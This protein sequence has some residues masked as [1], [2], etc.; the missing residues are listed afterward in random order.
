MRLFGI[1]AISGAQV[2]VAFG[3]LI[4]GVDELVEPVEDLPYVAPGWIDLQVNGYA[5]VDYNSPETAHEEIA[6]SIAAQ[7]Q[8]GT[9]RILATVITG[10]PENML[11]SLRNLAAAKVHGSGC[12]SIEG[13][14]VEGP[15]IS[16]E[17]GPRGAHPSRWVRPPAVDEYRRWQEVSDGWVKMVT[18]AP[19]WPGATAYIEELVRDGVVVAIGHTNATAVEIEEAVRAGATLSTHLGNGAHAMLPRQPNYIWDQLAD[20]RLAASFI[21][22]GHHLGASFLKTALRAKGVLRSVLVTDATMPAGSIPGPYEFGELEVELT[23]DERVVLRGSA[24]LAGSALSMDRAIGNTV[25]QTG[26]SL[27]EAVTMAT[28]NPARIGKIPG[29]QRGLAPGERADLAVFRF[30]ASTKTVAVEATY[31]GGELVFGGDRK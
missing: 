25:R 8:C 30:D 31:A 2:A 11:G 24:R 5:G 23:G 15:H 4:S 29:R 1:D 13:F 17:D 19:E 22:D 9:T 18:L 26:V 14:H 6:R 16:P 12:S 28:R 7:Q 10:A 20:D 21:V 27:A 3:S